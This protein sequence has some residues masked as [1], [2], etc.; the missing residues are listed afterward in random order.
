ME[1]V[2]IGISPIIVIAASDHED[3]GEGFNG[4]GNVYTDNIW[5]LKSGDVLHVDITE[6]EN[7]SKLTN[8]I[9]NI[10]RLP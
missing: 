7:G 3:D 4:G 9:I 5:Y 1:T 2:L 8:A 10:F 6:A